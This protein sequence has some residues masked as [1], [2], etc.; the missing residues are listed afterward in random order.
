MKN[1]NITGKNVQRLHFLMALT[2][3][4]PERK[5]MLKLWFK[6]N[7]HNAYVHEN[8]WSASRSKIKAFF[9]QIR[10]SLKRQKK[11]CLRD[12]RSL[13]FAVVIKLLLQCCGC[14]GDF[15]FNFINN[16]MQC[17]IKFANLM[18]T[19]QIRNSVQTNSALDLWT[20]PNPPAFYHWTI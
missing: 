4:W 18:A 3:M 17:L 11:L 9:F 10:I 2:Q 13:Y 19:A 5:Q 8:T 16:W 7:I 14:I 20:A 12:L 1:E 6:K 15:L